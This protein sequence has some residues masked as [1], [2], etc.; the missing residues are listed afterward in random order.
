MEGVVS[1]ANGITKTGSGTMI[2]SGANRYT[3][4]TT[5]SSGPAAV[6][7]DQS[8]AN[9]GWSVGPTAAA[10]ASAVFEAGSTV[11]VASGGQVRIGNTGVSGTSNQVLTVA[12]SVNNAG[13]LHVG[14]PGI[15]NLESGA[16][17]S[18]GGV[19]G[20]HAQ[21]GY[22]AILNLKTGATLTYTGSSP[23]ATNGA[24][25]NS[26][27]AFLNLS[28]GTLI[29]G[30]GFQQT[31]VPTTGFGRVTFSEGGIL[32]CSAD[33]PALSAGVRFQLGSG[34]GVI[35]TNGFNAT[36]DVPVDG[37]GGLGKDGAG[38]LTLAGAGTYA[39]D[40]IVLKGTLSVKA[41]SSFDDGSTVEVKPGAV[42]D[43]DFTGSDRVAGLILGGTAKAPG[44]YS[45]VTDPLHLDGDGMIVV[46]SP[47]PY[48]DWIL[49]FP[50]LTLPA[51]REKTANP[52]HD[53]LDN[54][55]EFALDGDPSNGTGS[56]KVV[57]RITTVGGSQVLALTLPVLKGAV[58]DP[59]L[60]G[61]GQL[62]LVAGTLRYA[63][64][65]TSD[66]A[67]TRIDVSELTGADATALAQGLPPLSADHEYRSFRLVSTLATAPRGFLS[68][69][70]TGLP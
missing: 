36:L 64:R 48:D 59:V 53:A 69:E 56:G 35:D 27:R 55:G 7:E 17:W 26:G 14:R 65:G 20:L 19:M 47:D 30:A 8:A 40:T 33:I 10:A 34:G 45:A 38:I 43:L 32:R 25:G 44:T 66:L 11:A 23:V 57:S 61:D 62:A 1:G 28:G 50:G 2:L 3:G 6:Y 54:L 5:I 63:I 70:I 58:A 12:G 41:D 37:P 52:D 16:T 49:T 51:D 15:L 4:I 42:L 9:G 60:P 29:T 13:T 46:S 22:D 18:Q 24:T 68:V 21:G 67:V 39:G 31:T